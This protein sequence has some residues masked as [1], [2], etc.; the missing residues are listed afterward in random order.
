MCRW[1]SLYRIGHRQ[2]VG[3]ACRLVGV[4]GTLAPS[5]RGFARM[6]WVGWS[7]A[8]GLP[9]ASGVIQLP[10]KSSTGLALHIHMLWL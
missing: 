10:A 6:G 9:Q 8:G 7:P 2:P 3:R 1:S 5:K 4:G